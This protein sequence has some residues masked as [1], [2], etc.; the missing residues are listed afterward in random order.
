[1]CDAVEVD[2]LP[3]VHGEAVRCEKSF[4]TAADVGI[5]DAEATLRRLLFDMPHQ[6][7]AYAAPGVSGVDEEVVDES[8]RL[9]IGI[10]GHHVP[11]HRDERPEALDARIPR[12]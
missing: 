7:G 9:Q 8:V 12:G 1:K 10:A 6:G 4:R 2:R 11:A 3:P 5:Q